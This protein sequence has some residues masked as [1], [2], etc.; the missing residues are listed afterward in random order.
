VTPARQRPRPTPGSDGWPKGDP[1]G[2]GD[3]VLY[4]GSEWDVIKLRDGMA[5]LAHHG[6]PEGK[7]MTVCVPADGTVAAFRKAADR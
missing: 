5:T 2:V 4:F 1:L 7:D 3:L 6:D